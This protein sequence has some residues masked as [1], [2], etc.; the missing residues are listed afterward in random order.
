MRA[1]VT[2]RSIGVLAWKMFHAQNSITKDQEKDTE[3]YRELEVPSTHNLLI[4]THAF[5]SHSMTRITETNLDMVI[6][7]E[8]CKDFKIA[9]IKMCVFQILKT[10]EKNIN[11]GKEIIKR[12][13]HE[14]GI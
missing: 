11:R 3:I 2:Q 10:A 4:I 5:S 7:D 12:G 13:S 1:L 6:R 14:I 8:I 9:V